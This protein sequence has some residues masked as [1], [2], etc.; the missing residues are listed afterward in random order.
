MADAQARAALLRTQLRE[1][2]ALTLLRADNAPAVVA[3][4]GT[5]F[6]RERR[7]IG[8]PDFL[9]ALDDD[10][11]GL[12]AAGFDLPQQSADYLADWVSRR[13][14][15]RRPDPGGDETLELSVGA[16]TALGVLDEVDAPRSG[17][18][19]SRLGNITEQVAR[20]A[21]DTNPDQGARLEAME[22]ERDA[23]DAA[24]ARA[25]TEGLQP[26]DDHTARERL[27][28]ILAMVIDL[29][30]DFAQVSAEVDR[31]NHELRGRLVRSGDSSAEVLAET[32]D[33]V[34]AVERSEAGRTF[35]AFH[36]LLLDPERSAAFDEALDEV[37]GRSFARDVPAERRRALQD[38]MVDLQRESAAVRDTMTSLS[39]S[40]RQFVSSRAW[41]G[42]ASLDAGIVEAQRVL[43]DLARTTSPRR[44]LGLRLDLS[45][46]AL[47][48]IAARA[49][50]RPGLVR[51]APGLVSVERQ[52]V[53]LA[54]LR[55]R[56]RESEIDLDE[57]VGLVDETLSIYPR[58]SIGDVLRRH[59]A[60][61]GL[62][63]VV[64]LYLLVQRHGEPTDATEVLA[65]R[66]ASGRRRRAVVQRHVFVHSPQEDAR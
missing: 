33:G 43:L 8:V 56:V 53:D 63:S 46:V 29:P 51:S 6:S 47:D 9:A 23:L 35:R 59:G 55:D 36:A 11:A 39:R 21:R 25:R 42:Q 4:L 16:A 50:Y 54:A 48:S 31:L 52:P 24:I 57:L 3:L 37:F 1:N 30:R 40:L 58:A 41:A 64:G 26:L 2:P 12:R 49:L 60:S 62:A 45:Q 44:D 13:W 28:E 65:W 14:L 18:T 34:D 66:S 61:Q 22:A 19:S 38:L 27:G 20:L 7:T 5:Q 17:L 15:V 10:L 32:F